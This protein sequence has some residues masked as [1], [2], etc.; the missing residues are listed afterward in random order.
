MSSMTEKKHPASQFLRFL[1]TGGVAALVNLL[2]RY[3]FNL[4]LPFGWSVVLAFP[5]GVMT[6]YILARLFVFS[7]SGRG[8]ASELRRFLLINVVGLF[9]VWGVSMGLAYVIFPAIRFA[10]HPEDV[11]HFIGVLSPM[12]PSFLGHRHFSFRK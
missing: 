7:S 4:F 6:A 11:A 8:V 3:V 1:M 12:V 10:W 9:I 5:L 2:S